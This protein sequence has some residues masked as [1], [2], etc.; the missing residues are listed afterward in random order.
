MHSSSAACVRGEARLIS[1]TS[2]TCVKTG[3]G[4]N[5]KRF[6]RWS[7]TLTPVTSDGR[8]SGVNCSREKEQ[9]SE[10]ASAFASIVFPTPGK[11]SMIRWP[12]PTRQYATSRSVSSGACT[13]RAT[14]PTSVSTAS[15]AA[16]AVASEPSTLRAHCSSMSPQELLGRV[17]HGCGD[18]R[19]RRLRHALLARGR[20][21]H[22]LVLVGVEADVRPRHVVVD[23]EIDVLVSEHPPLALQSGLAA[24]GAEGDDHL[25]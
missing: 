9:S 24:L 22:D 15:A 18:A 6:E 7:K 21:Q 20:D 19:L 23:D 16:S 10:R 14:L 3:P 8:R 1:S 13:T 11:P 17:E 4:R 25:S 2:R 5:S 12:S